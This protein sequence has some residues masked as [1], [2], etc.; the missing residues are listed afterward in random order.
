MVI[1]AEKLRNKMIQ[2]GYTTKMLAQAAGISVSAL[3][4]ILNGKTYE[5]R[6]THRIFLALQ[7]SSVDLI[8]L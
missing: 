1:D 3:Q 4:R 7:C 5:S 2:K 8:K 6:L